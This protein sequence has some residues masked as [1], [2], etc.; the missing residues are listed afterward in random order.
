MNISNTMI[1]TL[2]FI[3]SNDKTNFVIEKN[4]DVIIRLKFIGRFQPN[5]KVDVKNL[6]IEQNTL[7][8]PVKRL[9][10]GESRETTYNF[11]NS[12]IDRSFEII[13][14]FIKSKELS[15]RM[16]CK[17]ILNDMVK[18]IQGLKNIQ[19]TYRD[20]EIFKCNIEYMIETISF[21]LYDLREKFPDIFELKTIQ[22]E[23]DEIDEESFKEID[24]KKE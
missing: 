5:E 8:T 3:F 18:A 2:R 6:R 22:D 24:E 14:N 4:K 20:D 12:T 15:E 11:L 7:F 16:Y 19:K 1:N 9:L 23:I 13:N 10:F 21:K 17:N